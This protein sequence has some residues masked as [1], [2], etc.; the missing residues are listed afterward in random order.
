MDI[1]QLRL[2]LEAAQ[3]AG[4]G[5][6]G[7][8]LLWLG[9]QLLKSLLAYGCIGGL[10]IGAYKLIRRG[11]TNFSFQSKIEDITGTD[12]DYVSGRREILDWMKKE[13]K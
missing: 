8:A 13:Y 12:L 10:I 11:I 1:E 7:I 2:I 5:A 4:S 3:A 9:F 6:Y